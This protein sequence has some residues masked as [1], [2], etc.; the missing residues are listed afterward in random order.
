MRLEPEKKRV[1]ELRLI[2]DVFV[3]FAPMTTRKMSVLV[4]TGAEVNLIRRGIT[5]PQFLV[6]VKRPLKIAMASQAIMAG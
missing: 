1:K 6:P 3:E 4:D 5:Y 2:L